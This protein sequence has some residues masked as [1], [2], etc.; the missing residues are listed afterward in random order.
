M[1]RFPIILALWLLSGCEAAS[2]KQP[3]SP[4]DLATAQEPWNGEYV[5]RDDAGEIVQRTVWKDHNL[6]SAWE[7][8]EPLPR[9]WKQVAKNGTG[10]IKVYYR[11][12]HAGFNWFENG[13]FVRG[14]G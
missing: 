1:W 7:I 13:K 3:P 12:K 9:E 11:G 6:V 5:A 10:V 14:A 4:R 2:P 8:S